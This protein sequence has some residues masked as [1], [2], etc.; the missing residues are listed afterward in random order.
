MIAI[1]TFLGQSFDQCLF[2]LYK[3]LLSFCIADTV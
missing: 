1:S 3:N 2:C